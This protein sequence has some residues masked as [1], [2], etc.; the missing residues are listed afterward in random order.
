MKVLVTGGAGYIGSHLVQHLTHLGVKCYIIDNLSRGRSERISPTINFEQIDLC[1]FN[2]INKFI[3]SQN[4]DAVFHLAGFMQARESMKK[5]DLYFLNNVLATRNLIRCVTAPKRTKLIFGSSC[6]VYGNN[7]SA[8]EGSPILPLSNYAR[9]KAQ[10]EMELEKFFEDY[11]ENLSIFRFF[12]VIGCLDRPLFCD[13]QQETLLPASARK[14]LK[15]KRPMIYGKGF[16]TED[17]FAVRDFIDVRDVVK[18]LS[19]PLT[20]ELFGVH[21]LSADQA[22]SIGKIMNLLLDISGKQQLGFETVDSDT[23]DPSIIRSSTS[24]QLMSTG[25]KPD[26]LLRSSLENFWKV[27]VKFWD[28]DESC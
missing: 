10:S 6:S 11:P 19:I 5:P 2:K 18:A 4:F 1:D 25:W 24:I 13:I 21:N 27:F 26:F 17:G 23:A 16:D 28:S 14:I 22:I 20:K 7:S 12:N 9:T 8:H 3:R 15:G